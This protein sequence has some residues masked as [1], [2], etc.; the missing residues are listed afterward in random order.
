MP[1]CERP[2]C[3]HRVCV[4]G[5]AECGH[6]DENV[7][8]NCADCDCNYFHEVIEHGDTSPCI[9]REEQELCELAYDG[10]DPDT[11]VSGG[12]TCKTCGCVDI[13]RE[14]PSDY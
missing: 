10:G 4:C 2:I 13:N 3:Q 7:Q 1:L 6:A 5:H 14:P 11:G 9:D 8:P 12:W